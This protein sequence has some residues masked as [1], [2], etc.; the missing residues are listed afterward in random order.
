[1][2]RGNAQIH[3]TTRSG[4][5]KFAGMARWDIRNPALN[6][7][8]WV[9]HST[10]PVPAEPW[11]NQNQFTVSYGGPII[12]NKT[13]FFALYDQQI[14]RQRTP[15]NNTVLTPCAR[16]G[17]YRY[18]P[19]WVNGNSFTPTPAPTTADNQARASVDLA[20]N[21]VRPNFNPDGTPYTDSL[22]Y[23]SVFGPINFAAFPTTVAPD[24]SNIPLVNG[25]L[26]G[27]QTNP[28]NAWDVNRWNL[29]RTGFVSKVIAE[30]PL[31][32]NYEIGDGLNT[33]GNRYVRRQSGADGM[34]VDRDGRLYVAS[35]TGIQVFDARG[36]Y[37]GTIKFPRQPANA[38]FAGPGK[39]VLYVTAR[40]GLYRI[41]TMTKGPDRPGK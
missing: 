28:A 33:A 4:T 23:V 21:P 35:L 22:K 37:V 25:S 31:P 18:F 16:N 15:V 2:G 27:G 19:G 17:V 11:Y 8:T 5:D 29:D 14:H 41:N 40:E 6:A 39:N 24:C 12:R 34:A 36:Q 13:F 10:T 9:D 26:T 38:A 32:N 1:M 7:R 30:A 20:G 3:L